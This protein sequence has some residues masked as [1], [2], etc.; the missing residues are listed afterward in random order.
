MQAVASMETSSIK[1]SFL[2]IACA[3]LLEH[4]V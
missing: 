1:E 3:L 4:G 2:G